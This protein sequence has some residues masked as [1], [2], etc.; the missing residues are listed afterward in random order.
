LKK[1]RA[2]SSDGSF[3]AEVR[4]AKR[5][6]K[7]RLADW[8]KTQ[9]GMDIDLDTIFD[10]QVKRIHEYKRQLLNIV[11]LYRRTRE[12]P[13]PIATPRTFFFAGKAAPAYELAKVIIKF[14]NNLAR[15]FDADSV[16][17]DKLK[18]AFLPE[19]NV[20]LAERVI[21]ATDVSNQISTAGYE[22]SGTGNMK[23]MMNGELTLGTRDGATI[24]MAEEAGEENFFYPV[25]R[26]I[27]SPPAVP[28]TAPIGTIRTRR[29][30]GRLLI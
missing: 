26:R 28:G 8:S 18:V 20:S 3:Q 24:E 13:D 9:S 2:L 22:A 23:F 5:I 17:R 11:V 1:L 14:I 25:S 29:K 15:T 19:Y 10:C 27:K 30:R 16:V 7:A 12:N 6:A 4:K 21:P